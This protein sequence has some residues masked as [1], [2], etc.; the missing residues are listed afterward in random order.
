M[1][2]NR[3]YSKTDMVTNRKTGEAKGEDEDAEEDMLSAQHK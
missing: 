1:Q 3:Q 2:Q